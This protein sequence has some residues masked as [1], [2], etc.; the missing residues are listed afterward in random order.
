MKE[1]SASLVAR[2][3]IVCPTCGESIEIKLEGLSNFGWIPT[4]LQEFEKEAGYNKQD[5]EA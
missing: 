2:V 5:K 1:V 4:W 3:Y